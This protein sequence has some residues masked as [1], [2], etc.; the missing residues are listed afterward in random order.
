MCAGP[1]VGLWCTW[2]V[3]Q[4]GWVCSGWC[5]KGWGQLV[6]AFEVLLA[7]VVQSVSSCAHVWHAYTCVACVCVCVCHSKLDRRILCD[8]FVLMQN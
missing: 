7:V 4:A 8:L 3:L 1:A 5:S 6:R 2:C